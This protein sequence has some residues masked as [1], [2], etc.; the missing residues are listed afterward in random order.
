[1][2]TKIT[3]HDQKIEI[4]DGK[5]EVVFYYNELKYLHYDA[6]FCWLHFTD[7][8]KYKV[9]AS[10]QFME[11]SL[12]SSYFFRCN[13]SIIL[14]ICYYKGL[15]LSPPSIILQD[16]NKFPLSRRKVDAFRSMKKNPPRIPP[17][18]AECDAC[19]ERYCANR[20]FI[21]IEEAG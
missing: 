8:S 1:M 7:K 16:G 19:K 3:F 4:S 12:P 17:P 9:E 20:N 14:N 11:V 6:P 15:I 21:N 18:C 13:R 5:R 2:K 10:L